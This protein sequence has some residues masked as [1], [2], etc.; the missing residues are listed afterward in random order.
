M[1]P[2]REA[3][4]TYQEAGLGFPNFIPGI[5]GQRS[6]LPPFIGFEDPSERE[7]LDY[8]TP[9]Q[10]ELERF[11]QMRAGDKEWLNRDPILG[12]TF[13]HFRLPN[14]GENIH[15][16]L[17][18][19]TP[20]NEPWSLNE[21][22]T[23]RNGQEILHLSVET[24]QI[25]YNRHGWH[26]PEGHLFRPTP[27]PRKTSKEAPPNVM[28]RRGRHRFQHP[29][30]SGHGETDEKTNYQRERPLFV[31]ACHGDVVTLELENRLPRAFCGSEFDE[32][33][34]PCEKYTV[35]V[36]GKAKIHEGDSN[37]QADRTPPM[38]C[39]QHV[40][41]VKFDPLV[42]DGAATGWNYLSGARAPFWDEER[43]LWK[44][45]RMRYIWW[46]DEEFGVIFTHDH[47][48]ANFRQKR[49]LFGAMIAE[50]Q[51][52]KYVQ[53][54]DHCQEARF[55][56]SAVI[57]SE[58]GEAFRE[59]CIA[60]GD[61][62]P[63]YN[64]HNRP[65]NKPTVPGH[66][67]DH[68]VVGINY[69]SAPIR[70]RFD[71]GH[72]SQSP[73]SE[74]AYS[75]SSHIWG[76]PETP[77]FQTRPN[78]PVRIR[79]FQ[80]SHEEQHSFQIHGMRWP[81]FPNGEPQWAN[82]QTLG[83]SEQFSLHLETAYGPGD[84]LYKFA[85]SDDLWMGAWGILRV[86]P[87]E[88]SQPL[89]LPPSALPSRKVPEQTEDNTVRFTL[90]AESQEIIYL[91]NPRITDPFG[92]VFRREETGEVQSQVPWP[93]VKAPR[94]PALGSP[95]V[96]RCPVGSWVEI[97]LWNKLPLH[98]KVEPRAPEV[99]VERLDRSV[100]SR[101]SLHADMVTYDVRSDD[102]VNV[103]MNPL[104]TDQ[105]VAPLERKSETTGHYSKRVY[106]WF[107]DLEGPVL[108]QDFADF[109]NHRHH[110]LVGALIVEPKGSETDESLQDLVLILQDGL[111]LFY[112]GNLGLPL[113]DA[114]PDPGEN[115]DPTDQGQKAINFR[116]K[117]IGHPKWMSGAVP[118]ELL[119]HVKLGKLR[120]HLLVAG[121]KPRNHVFTIHG[122]AWPEW[123]Q[124]DE[125][126]KTW[127]GS[128]N[129]MSCGMVATLDL[130]L[131]HTGDHALRSGALAWAVS[132]GMWSVLRVEEDGLLK[133]EALVSE[134]TEFS[135]LVS[136]FLGNVEHNALEVN[137]G[138]GTSFLST[139]TGTL[140]ISDAFLFPSLERD[141]Q[142]LIPIMS[143]SDLEI[144]TEDPNSGNRYDI[145]VSA[146]VACGG[147]AKGSVKHW[148]DKLV[149]LKGIRFVK[150]GGNTI[151]DY[152]VYT[153]IQSA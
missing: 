44:Y 72:G 11:D 73:K 150:I 79:L 65:L 142:S 52:S 32:A 74:L 120:V 77:I 4:P 17:W 49:G 118:K 115:V 91:D 113:P 10:S 98:L 90:V 25:D 67:S 137:V 106:R 130:Q 7:G 64:Q 61:F 117:P 136:E 95:L 128:L 81:R 112:F 66:H 15:S 78:E 22:K 36:D 50:P 114:T 29:N 55:D 107:A 111:R 13:N 38:P 80:G 58:N 123:P 119:Y 125:Q 134:P 54:H 26:D 143:R 145:S 3:P 144:L 21:V 16:D 83:I 9:H 1:L 68:G 88:Q 138:T 84:Y 19:E 76:D 94:K 116:A 23:R 121:D 8:R 153:E 92:L 96:L 18:L 103:G 28:D 59:F 53:P 129:A 46:V 75:F 31:R 149:Q 131:K 146:I 45:L 27:G 87:E 110:G 34:P 30:S 2:D 37:W 39:G 100:S 151:I 97:T 89:P 71:P 126:L 101:V 127:V 70:E 86:A 147:D 14:P 43:Q 42:C 33:L 133:S 12:W 141:G 41:L 20:A 57:V 35:K 40:H 60:L 135:E 63:L 51:G 109:R 24:S 102:G 105:T 6:P 82:Q 62:V 139:I 93:V 48:F 108:L 99:P 47:L 104:A 56:E 122:H 152:L 140:R 132:Q 85:S 5:P 124:S 148:E 69:R